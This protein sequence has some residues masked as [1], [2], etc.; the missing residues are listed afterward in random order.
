MTRRKARENLN[1]ILMLRPDLLGGRRSTGPQLS[2][3]AVMM[4]LAV[5]V[6]VLTAIRFFHWPFA[7]GGWI[8]RIPI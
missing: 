3:R 5:L 8:F 2:W 7:G 1:L 6:S 4:I